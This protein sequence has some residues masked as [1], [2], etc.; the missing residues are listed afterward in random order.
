MIKSQILSL[1]GMKKAFGWMAAL[2]LYMLSK[3]W[4]INILSG[5]ETALAVLLTM[6][7]M[8]SV[9]MSVLKGSFGTTKFANVFT[10]QIALL[11]FQGLVAT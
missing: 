5:D 7:T 3:L 8:R 10:I 11:H 2:N 4:T 9:K 6:M 1:I